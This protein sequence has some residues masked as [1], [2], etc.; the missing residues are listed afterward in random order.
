ME[1]IVL[2]GDVVRSRQRQDTTAWLERLSERLDALY[3]GSL[4]AAFDF[5]QGD[6]LQGLLRLDADPFQA[7]LTAMLAMGEDVPDMRWVVAAGAI[8]PG[9]GPAT[10]R[11]GPA[12]L[13]ARALIE[14]AR[15]RRDTLIVRTGDPE[16]DTLLD[17]TAPVLASLI[18]RLT[19][20][21]RKVAHLALVEGLRQSVIAERLGVRRATVSVSFTRGD[22]RSLSR[23]LEAVRKLWATGLRATGSTAAKA[24][25]RH[26]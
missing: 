2:F 10:R 24:G 11:N 17:D 7:A 21:Q 14:E 9:R 19:R 15:R 12:F 20:R 16:T 22:V 4:L 13:V 8:D 18:E 6:E 1:G 5:T 25:S 3:R 23:L 26:E